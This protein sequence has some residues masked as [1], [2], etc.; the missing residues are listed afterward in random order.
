MIELP[1]HL[2]SDMF[3]LHRSLNRNEFIVFFVDTAGEG[4]DYNAGHGLSKTNLDLPITLHYKGSIV[5][6]TPKLKELLIWI[7]K[8]TGV[9]PV[10]CYETNNGGGYEFDRLER[11]N[12]EQAY[13]IY[14]QYVLDSEGKLTRTDKKGWNTNSATRPKMLQDVEELV[15]NHLVVIYDEETVNEM[16]SF[17]KMKS[18]ASWKA[19]AETGA[20]D[21]LIMALAGVWQLYQTETPL[22]TYSQPSQYKPMNFTI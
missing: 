2:D 22:T 13:R 16:F 3:T 1:E 12:I 4:S 8:T 21:D 10:V 15:N 20:H 6:V 17:V 14:Y 5:D 9:K 7:Y 19:Q 11:L 18:A